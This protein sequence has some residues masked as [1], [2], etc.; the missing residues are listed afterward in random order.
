MQ[1]DTENTTFENGS[2]AFQVNGLLFMDDSTDNP[3]AEATNSESQPLTAIQELESFASNGLLD[4]SIDDTES[5]RT[6]GMNMP[7]EERPK[8]LS[9]KDSINTSRSEGNG[10]TQ[11]MQKDSQQ[12]EGTQKLIGLNANNPEFEST[13]NVLPEISAPEE[14]GIQANGLLFEFEDVPVEDAIQMSTVTSSSSATMAV[15]T[16]QTRIIE[17]DTTDQE[18]SLDQLLEEMESVS[19]TALEKGKGKVG[20]NARSINTTAASLVRSAM[21]IPRAGT[22]PQGGP[23]PESLSIYSHLNLVSLTKE[24]ETLKP[25]EAVDRNGKKVVFK[26]KAR[27]VVDGRA[28]SSLCGLHN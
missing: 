2:S 24:A 26:R 19:Y 4:G 7:S 18:S 16:S 17:Q 21:H 28:V 5:F 23:T 1:V 13:A 11:T 10:I 12:A 22:I 25:L 9:Q 27:K 20:A 3:S 6:L 14:Q 8:S 15:T